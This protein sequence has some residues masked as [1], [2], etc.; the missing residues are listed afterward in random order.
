VG[1]TR[2]ALPVLLMHTW[3]YLNLPLTIERKASD[4]IPRE[5]A[6]GIFGP[7]GAHAGYRYIGRPEMTK[8]CNPTAK[9]VGSVRELRDVPFIMSLISLACE[10]CY[11]VSVIF[12]NLKQGT[13]CLRS[14]KTPS[15]RFPAP[16]TPFDFSNALMSL[17]HS[18]QR[19]ETRCRRT[20]SSPSSWATSG[21]RN[22][23]ANPFQ[24]NTSS[25]SRFAV[26]LAP[27]VGPPINGYV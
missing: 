15:A 2:W 25:P 22:G 16:S 7:R 17:A 26:G 1:A 21:A 5:A 19:I 20:W 12:I 27:R 11:L 10:H 9:S 18:W 3:Q 23:Y 24:K 13:R 8:T 14:K 6:L 4:L